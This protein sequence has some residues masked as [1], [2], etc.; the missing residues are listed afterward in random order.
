M[1][2][3]RPFVKGQDEETYVKIFNAAFAK[4]YEDVRAITL[5][6]MSKFEKSPSYSKKAFLWPK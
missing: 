5:E 2:K 4:E 1:L 6:E 3:I